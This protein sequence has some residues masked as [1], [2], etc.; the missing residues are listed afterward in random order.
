MHVYLWATFMILQAGDVKSGKIHFSLKR[1]IIKKHQISL[2]SWTFYRTLRWVRTGIHDS[3]LSV[4]I[5][6]SI[7][8]WWQ[9]I[10]GSE[11][12]N[13]Q[14]CEFKGCFEPAILFPQASP[15][16]QKRRIFLILRFNPPDRLKSYP[17]TGPD[18]DV[19]WWDVE[20]NFCPGRC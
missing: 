12:S 9:L 14:V 7:P 6:I 5:T 18:S 17:P 11:Y 8:I 20:W 19:S 10:L 3:H 2:K 1:K 4:G 15:H 16:S 13:Y